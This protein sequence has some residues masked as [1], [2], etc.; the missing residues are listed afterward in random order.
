MSCDD[1]WFV[2]VDEGSAGSAQQPK[3]R[4]RWKRGSL[5]DTLSKYHLPRGA[6]TFE[7]LFNFPVTLLQAAFSQPEWEER[8]KSLLQ[9]GVVEHSDYSGVFAERESKRLLF[10]A[11][12]EEQ[13][14]FVPHMVTK[15]CDN[16]EVC[17][18]VLIHASQVMDEQCSCVFTDIRSQIHPEAQ[19]WCTAALPN[20]TDPLQTCENAYTDIANF[21]LENS[22]WVVDQDR[23]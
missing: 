1:G 3:K 17:Q 14:F 23:F 11:L 20:P 2:D 22:A 7:E 18:S 12:R 16:D 15:T 9:R 13:S 4:R 5:M 8:C 10:Q 21:L 6:E 19:E